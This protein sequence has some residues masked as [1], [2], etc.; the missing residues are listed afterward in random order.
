MKLKTITIDLAKNVFQVCGVN[1]HIKP[2]FNKK[3]KR[4]ELLDFMRQQLPTVVVMEAC[5]SS[6]YWGREIAKLGHDTKLIPAQH[7]T[8]FVR[9]NKN[10]HNDAFAIAEAS[11][12]A[13]IR[14]VPVKSEH[15]QE[16]SCLHRIRERL[17]KNKTAMSNQARGLLSEFGVVFPCGHKA[18]LNGL[19]SVIDNPQYS[20]RLQD[21]VIDMLSEYDITLNRLKG[22]E[23]QLGEFVD[24]SESGKIL[25]SIPGIGVI[26]VS[27]LLAAIDKGQAFNNPKEFAVW[28]GLTPKQHASGNISKMGGIT[29]R[30]DRY[31]RKQLIHGA[32]AFVSRAAKST[33]P[34]ALWA[35]KLRVTKPFNKVAVAMAHRLARLIWILLT[36]QERYR[37]A[38]TS[39]E[40]S[41]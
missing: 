32:R 21:M 36:R 26:N 1:Q 34:L 23:K 14:F 40:V 39:Q 13:H 22:I 15:Q 7:V 5:Y 12:R 37:A 19:T 18:L 3:L 11:Q 35:T 33:D 4:N 31:L 41:A 8:P 10:D 28:L 20:H 27:A 29:K 9:G 6:H 16:I 17:I 25:R 2:Q 30:G 38:S 24:A